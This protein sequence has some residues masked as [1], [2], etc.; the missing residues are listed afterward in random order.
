MHVVPIF[1]D[2]RN[3]RHIGEHPG[4]VAQ[5]EQGRDELGGVHGATPSTVVRIE[6]VSE[7]PGQRPRNLRPRCGLAMEKIRK[8]VGMFPETAKQFQSKRGV[9]SACKVAVV[10]VLDD[11]RVEAHHEAIGHLHFYARSE[12]QG[13]WCR[14]GKDWIA[15]F[16]KVRICSDS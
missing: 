9:H 8:V 1:G 15:T 11:L 6:I 12:G 4:S 16:K 13:Q 10:P 3:L 2:A 14:P 7:Q 5:G